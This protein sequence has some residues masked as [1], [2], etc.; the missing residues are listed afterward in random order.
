MKQNNYQIKLPKN[1]NNYNPGNPV[2]VRFGKIH[3]LAPTKDITKHMNKAHIVIE[4]QE[5]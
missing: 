5:V 2:I 4:N 3:S 1:K